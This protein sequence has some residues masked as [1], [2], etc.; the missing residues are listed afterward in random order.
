MNSG[1]EAYFNHR[2]TGLPAFSEGGTGLGTPGGKLP[3]RWLYPLDEI[4]SNNANYQ[5]AIASQ[6]GG[7]EDVF[8]DTWLTK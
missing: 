8:K 1:W 6:F 4:N 7:A 2:R 5:K 3:R